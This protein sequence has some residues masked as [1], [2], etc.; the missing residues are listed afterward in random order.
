MHYSFGSFTLCVPDKAAACRCKDVAN[1]PLRPDVK[2]LAILFE[3]L[4]HFYPE[5]KADVPLLLFDLFY[6][7]LPI[8]NLPCSGDMVAQGPHDEPIPALFP[9]SVPDSLALELGFLD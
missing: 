3:S 4:H 5:N 1:L 8:E 9:V 7:F 6:D 2:C